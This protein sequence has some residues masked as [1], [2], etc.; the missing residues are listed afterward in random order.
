MGKNCLNPSWRIKRELHKYFLFALIFI[1]VFINYLFGGWAG[2]SLLCVGFSRVAVSGGQASIPFTP[3]VD[4]SFLELDAC[5]HLWKFATWRFV[6]RE[7]TVLISY[8]GLNN[9]H[10]L[11]AVLEARKSKIKAEGNSMSGRASWFVEG[12]PHAMSPRGRR[13]KGAL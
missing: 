2:S 10:L 1:Y 6:C 3:H 13:G 7:L 11:F 4:G 12:G 5:S 8:W 9:Q